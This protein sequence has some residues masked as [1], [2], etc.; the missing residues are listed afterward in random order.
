MIPAL[1]RASF[2]LAAFGVSLTSVSAQGVAANAEPPGP[3]TGLIVGQVVDAVTG[4]P[5]SGAVIRLTMPKYLPTLPTTPGGR[6]LTDEAGRYFFAGLPAGEFFLRASKEG[7]AGGAYGLRSADDDGQPLSLAEGERRIDAKLPLWKYGAIEGTVV[8]EAGEAVVGVQVY[9]L[10][11]GVVGGR[12]HFGQGD[13]LNAGPEIGPSVLTDDRGVFRIPRVVPGSYVIVVPSTQTTIPAATIQSYSGNPN[14]QREVMIASSEV[15]VL[16][17]PRT[18]QI[19]EMALLT[20][21]RVPAPPPVTSDGRW[22][23]YRTTYFPSAAAAGAAKEIVVTP[24]EERLN[25]NI[26]LV[27]APA[28][29]VSGRLVTPDGS[30]PPAM[31][32]RLV[33]DAA[34]EVG[35]NGFETAT[36]VSDTDGRFTFLA[37][38]AG[39]YVF[40]TSSRVE[41]LSRQGLPAFWGTQHVSV[42][43]KN[44]ANL[45]IDLRPAIRLEGRVEFHAATGDG[46]KHAP[47]VEFHPAFGGSDRF[48][49]GYTDSGTFSVT[50]TGGQYVISPYE[51]S[52]WF[53]D[54]VVLDGKNIADT[55]VD[56]QTITSPI[57]ITYTDKPTGLSGTVKSADGRPSDTA[58]VLTF[59]TNRDHWTGYGLRP[60]R[61]KDVPA[62]RA[63]AF[64]FENLPPGEY[65]VIAV[66]SGAISGWM[67]PKN[68]EAL[69]RDAAT[70][71]IAGGIS[72]T[73]DLTMKVIR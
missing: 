67:D 61:V 48:A 18:E 60:R 21:N 4:D 64:A 33:S 23:V 52:G 8:D 68:L 29:E 9:A 45:T 32:I 28:V 46:P 11:R 39:E 62:S 56:L 26:V 54:A 20:K 2:A 19:G 37:V 10:K 27:P 31:A 12:A 15:Q 69:A 50:S 5:I 47:G 66:D 43:S 16:G 72:K 55:A 71:R 40:K 13:N 36:A 63:G 25:A 6:V 41:I 30:A 17:Q 42:G 24:G 22:S 58:T 70:I 3:R 49:A 35:E 14:V 38:P 7:F 51:V 59:S 53:V 57:V 73:L 44:V 34:A 1:R 65:Y